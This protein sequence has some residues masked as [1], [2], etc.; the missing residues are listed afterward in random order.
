MNLRSVTLIAFAASLLAL[1]SS[2]AHADCFDDAAAYQ[3]VNPIIL[4]AIAW[5]ESHNRPDALHKNANGSIDYGLMQINSIH[6]PKLAS[7]GISH[8]TLMKP[9]KAIYI[10]AWHLRRQ[11]DKYG[12]TWRAVGSYHSET[13]ALRDQ[14]AKQ[15]KAILLK[16]KNPTAQR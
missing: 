7:Y 1:A 3:H 6:L 14:Y 16:W 13:P 10:A 12:N 5:Q 4:R 2:H 15:I 9:C 8:Q 11:M